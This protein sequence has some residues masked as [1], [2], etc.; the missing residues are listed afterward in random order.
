MRLVFDRILFM[1]T[2][3]VTVKLNDDDVG[4]GGSDGGGLRSEIGCSKRVMGRNRWEK[5]NGRRI[6]KGEGRGG[7]AVMR[8]RVQES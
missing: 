7:A 4:G 6:Y 8:R 1:A 5:E 3:N 2:R